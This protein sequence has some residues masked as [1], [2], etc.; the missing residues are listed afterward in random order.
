MSNRR[1]HALP[2]AE[3]HKPSMEGGASPFS[4]AG[5]AASAMIG[6]WVR[7]RDAGGPPHSG[8]EIGADGNWRHLMWDGAALALRGGLDHEGIVET[9]IDTSVANG[10]NGFFQIGIR[11]R[12]LAR[13]G[14]LWNDKMIFFDIESD[15]PSVYV[16]TDRIATPAADVP[17]A[18][19][20]RAGAPSCATA[21]AG[22]VDLRA[23]EANATL[24]G[25]W[26]L[27]GSDLLQPET[28]LE[29]DG[30]GGLRLLD[31][32]G[33]EIQFATYRAINPTTIPD[34]YLETVLVFDDLSTSWTIILSEQPL[35]LW[36][37]TPGASRVS[38]HAIF[39]A[40][41]P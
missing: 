39:A 18:P 7:C 23:S 11:G 6:R 1:K 22:Y 5:E 36:M 30:R 3:S 25:R 16:R 8:L 20:E 17:Y 9:P 33:T 37:V 14:L 29:F 40:E 4:N 27:C 31:A 13:A 38:R 21:E 32:S 19:R 28:A 15:Q 2:T 12:T 35:K 34:T 26:T 24:A 10:R 41:S